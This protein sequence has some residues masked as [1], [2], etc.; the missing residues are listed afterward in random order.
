M[1]PRARSR[2]WMANTSIVLVLGA[3]AL[4]HP[5]PEP[6]RSPNAACPN[7]MPYCSFL[8]Y[9]STPPGPALQGIS[10]AAEPAPAFGQTCGDDMTTLNGRWMYNWGHTPAVYNYESVPM[11]WGPW[12]LE[13][14]A[15]G[16][17]TGPSPGDVPWQDPGNALHREK[18]VQLAAKVTLDSGRPSSAYLELGGFSLGVPT[19]AIIRGIQVIVTRS[20]SAQ[21]NA[22]I[23]DSE[24]LLV[25]PNGTL[26][27]DRAKADVWS[28]T[29]GAWVRYGGLDL[30]GLTWTAADL[31]SP[32]FKVRI[33]VR[34]T[35][36]AAANATASIGVVWVRPFFVPT[37]VGGNSQHL[38][39]FNEP[40]LGGQAWL[41]PD[42][43]AVLW[44]DLEDRYG[45]THTL[46]SPAPSHLDLDWLRRFREAYHT[47]S[48]QEGWPR[49]WP[50]LDGIAC[51]TY[52]DVPD[53]QRTVQ[54]YIDYATAWGAD[55]GVWLTEFAFG[56]WLGVPKQTA[57]DKAKTFIS[58]LK[59][60]K[61]VRRYAW[62]TNRAWDGCPNAPN[63]P[64]EP[65]IDYQTN[66]LTDY[67]SMYRTFGP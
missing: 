37:S 20:A 39:G 25:H 50:K 13:G 35:A 62:F 4:D 7:G 47:R 24:V 59:A 44:R 65:L 30:W 16:N 54:Q 53:A 15:A 26:S 43:A 23:A 29:Q 31:N 6:S 10:C 36:Q 9:V 40:D 49:A 41:E 21:G 42:E 63:C 46:L 27:A 45:A 28:T 64:L 8:P 61:M 60:Q 12:Y 51:H 22:T 18:P 5:Q 2:W 55:Q 14:S 58:W 3:C 48:L 66:G 33:R 67:G 52:Q 34:A 56:E 19:D 1:S 32:D 17:V 38:L 11:L 57:I